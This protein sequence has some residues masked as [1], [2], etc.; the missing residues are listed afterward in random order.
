MEQ[1]KR[2]RLVIDDLLFVLNML[3]LR[4]LQKGTDLLRCLVFVHYF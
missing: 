4:V 2:Y 3:Y 1:W